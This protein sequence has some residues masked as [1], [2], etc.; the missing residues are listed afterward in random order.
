M[1]LDARVSLADRCDAQ[2]QQARRCRSH[3]YEKVFELA[4][5]EFAFK[6]IG[7]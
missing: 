6:D 7:G 5:R 3:E 1:C 4:G 2:V